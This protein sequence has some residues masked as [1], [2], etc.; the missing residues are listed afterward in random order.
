MRQLDVNNMFLNGSLQ[1]EV[2]MDQLPGFD[3]GQGLVVSY[4]K[5]SMALSRL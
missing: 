1:E 2:Y 4:I 3:Q 5:L